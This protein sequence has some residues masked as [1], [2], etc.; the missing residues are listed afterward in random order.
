MKCKFEHD[1]DCCNSGS[2]QYMCK[3]KPNVCG[4][5]VPMSHGDVFRTSSDEDLARFLSSVVSPMDCPKRV[6]D[7]YD[8]VL[9]YKDAWLEWLQ[10]P[11]E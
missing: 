7:L 1:E 8:S 11:C 2:L 10:E 9:S 5:C 6:W 4:A 3:C